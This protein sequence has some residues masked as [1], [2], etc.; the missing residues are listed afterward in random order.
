MGTNMTSF[1]NSG[2]QPHIGTN[3]RPI[4]LSEL[5]F[6]DGFRITKNFFEN[7]RSESVNCERMW[8]FVPKHSCYIAY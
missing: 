2:Y 1:L 5:I 8:V 7:F 6:F 4:A 3:M